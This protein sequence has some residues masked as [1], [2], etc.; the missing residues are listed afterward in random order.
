MC[1]D[2]INQSLWIAAAWGM[3][4]AVLP[5]FFASL[6]VLSF[7][8][9]LPPIV[10]WT[11]WIAL[12]WGA[13]TAVWGGRVCDMF[14]FA[15]FSFF[16]ISASVVWLSLSL[17]LFLFEIPFFWAFWSSSFLF[18]VTFCRILSFP[19]LLFSLLGFHFLSWSNWLFVFLS[20][21]VASIR[22]S[23]WA[24]SSEMPIFLASI[25]QGAFFFVKNN[26]CFYCFSLHLQF[27]SLEMTQIEFVHYFIDMI[28]IL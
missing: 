8:V 12:V 7:L 17:F 25:T 4:P 20:F 11:A 26:S 1:T 22:L 14:S 24:F 5:V 21:A 19:V 10:L 23:L 13:G 15:C 16:V 6:L 18:F 3:G 28:C 2:L 27:P 9:F